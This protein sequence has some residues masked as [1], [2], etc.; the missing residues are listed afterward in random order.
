MKDAQKLSGQK[1]DLDNLGDVYAA[2]HV[3]QE[4]LGLTGVA[5]AE[6]SET[7]TGSFEAMKAAGENLMAAITSGNIDSIYEYIVTLFD[8]T[9]TFV[10][11]NL[12][13]MLGRIVARLPQLLGN[14]MDEVGKLLSEAAKNVGMAD[15]FISE[16]FVD[17]FEVIAQSL[18]SLIQGIIE[19]MV[20]V[21]EA[22]VNFDYLGFI[23]N[24]VDGIIS[25]FQEA[26]S[27]Y[28]DGDTSMLDML[29]QWFETTVP[30]MLKEGATLVLN[31][32]NGIISNLPEVIRGASQVLAQFLATV[33]QHLPKII[34]AGFDIL[35]K[36]IV[37]LI[38]CIP[39]LIAAIPKIISAIVTTFAK[40]D[41]PSIG[42]DI[43]EGVKRGIIS[44][45]SSVVAAA[46]EAAAEIY[47]AVKDFFQIGSPSKLM[48]RE[49]GRW[50]P[51]GIA[52]GIDAN[53]SDVTKSMK[54]LTDETLNVGKM[55]I[56]N[57]AIESQAGMP[58]GN[59]F[60]QTLNITTTD[61]SPDE[62]ARAIRLESKYGLIVGG[63]LG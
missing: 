3:I 28:G 50:I 30:H 12:A 27:Y 14:L 63:A 32:V 21:F 45:V 6:A 42:R 62:L 15:G 48:A 52:V 51:A 7:F 11:D 59:T 57:Y 55:T 23:Q 26:F 1:Y 8:T 20:A 18:P 40:Y 46:K 56:P 39:D 49:I 17:L 5:A 35:T 37:G 43:L 33:A 29:L 31:I 34:A 4:D 47:N 36:L 24:I 10:F 9:E 54:A 44:A 53:M 38:N 19:F 58:M 25:G 16:F 60:N 41:W 61:S 13:P 22:I 2:I